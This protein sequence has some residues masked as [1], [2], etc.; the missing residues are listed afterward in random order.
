MNKL[1]NKYGSKILCI[2]RSC[3]FSTNLMKREEKMCV[4]VCVCNEEEE[5]YVMSFTERL[6]II[7]RTKNMA[8]YKKRQ[9]FN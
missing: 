9:A 8:K 7:K 2:T 4:C 1:I 3:G 5:M 6:I